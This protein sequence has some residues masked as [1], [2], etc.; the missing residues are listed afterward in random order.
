M[1]ITL[2]FR[3]AVCEEQSYVV[4][5]LTGFDLVEDKHV[6]RFDQR[7]KSEALLNAGLWATSD[8]EFDSGDLGHEL[9]KDR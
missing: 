2:E 4:F 9:P 3:E 8:K 7:R 5:D 6:R 1:P